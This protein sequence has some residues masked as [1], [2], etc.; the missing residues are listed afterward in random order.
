MATLEA[1]D[2]LNN[3]Y[4]DPVTGNPLRLRTMSLADL[5]QV[6]T[7]EAL[8]FKSPW[9][10]KAFENEVTKN[11]FSLPWVVTEND[12][13][14]AYSV[15]WL[16]VDEM[17][18]GNFAVDPAYQKRGIASWLMQNIISQADNSHVR[19]INLEVRRSNTAAISLYKKFAF[20]IVGVRKNYYK[21][22]HEDALL[23]SR[24]SIQSK[25]NLD[26]E[27]SWSGSSV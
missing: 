19:Q 17:H 27:A 13:I 23:M 2:A 14:L 20:K 12:K 15:A 10:R 26:M 16:I 21:A 9:S 6:C 3:N 5:D 1:A 24:E 18:I 11:S 4:I 25:A 8:I 7:L 22:E